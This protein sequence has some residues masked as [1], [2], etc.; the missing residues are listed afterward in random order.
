MKKKFQ[1]I[2]SLLLCAIMAF[3]AVIAC[4]S[5]LVSLTAS[6]D[7]ET[8]KYDFDE[9]TG[10]L[11]I[12]GTGEITYDKVEEYENIK[13]VEI[14]DG[15]T[16]IGFMAFYNCKSLTNITIPAS[17]T[18]I[19]YYTLS[20]CSNLKDINVAEGNKNY[21]SLDGVLFNKKVTELIQY[22]VSKDKTTYTIPNTV[23][24]IDSYAFYGCTSLTSIAIPDGVKFIDEGTF[25]DCA[26]LTSI[27]IPNSVIYISESAFNGCT[28][29]KNVKIGD[30][31]TYIEQYAFNGCTSLTSITIPN[32]VTS[33]GGSAF[34]GCTSLKNIV[35][36]D[37]VTEIVSSAFENTA[38]Y[39]NEDNWQDGVLYIGN[40]LIKAKDTISGAYKIK[41]GTKAIAYSA[42]YGCTSLT[43][44]IIP[45][46]VTSIGAYAFYGCTSLKNIVIGDKV[47]EIVS[48]A[49][50][51]TAYYNNEDNWQDG[52][53]YIGNCLIKAKDTISGAYKIK[54]G[55]KAIAGDAFDGCTGLTSITIPDS[56]TSIGCEA[57]GFCTGLTSITIPDSVTSIEHYTFLGCSS[58]SEINYLGCEGQWNNIDIGWL[59][60]AP[61]FAASKTFDD[62]DFSKGKVK[63]KAGLF[64]EGTKEY[65]CSNDGCSA[66]RTE[67]IPSI[68]TSAINKIL[69]FFKNIF[70]FKF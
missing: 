2:L 4:S 38:Y 35:I 3:G 10:T 20:A 22:P 5:G 46:S 6:A 64:T 30:G 54:D 41:D 65:E 62:H 42:F 53:L 68:F 32:S 48:S 21:S 8:A 59:Y 11:T 61:L 17:I 24:N 26:G 44:V 51:N 67:T 43:S 19:G 14:K 49:F 66:T 63:E 33:I 45:N 60:N 7:G 18:N 37:K 15:I 12:S 13:K 1:K 39:N 69:D 34:Y 25:S 28:N 55:T 50:E 29:L 70:S 47:T 40:C 58:L 52:V 36:G 56:V 31:V 27:T 23:N 16:S 57:F 9:T